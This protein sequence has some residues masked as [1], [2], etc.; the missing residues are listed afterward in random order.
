V[1]SQELALKMSDE[2]RNLRTKRFLKNRI[3]P[4][5][6]MPVIYIQ[7]IN[8]LDA[9][10]KGNS[11][12]ICILDMKQFVLLLGLL[13]LG[14]RLILLVRDMFADDEK[15]PRSNIM[16]SSSFI[17]VYIGALALTIYYLLCRNF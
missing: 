16:N 1:A 3:I 5:M 4:V 10:L 7:V 12:D 11:M 13:L 14:H 2:E 8:F 6:A 15:E 17:P 9:F